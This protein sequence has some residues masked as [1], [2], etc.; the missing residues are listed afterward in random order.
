[1]GTS[2]AFNVYA[3]QGGSATGGPVTGGSATGGNFTKIAPQ[4]PTKVSF[5]IK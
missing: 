3:Q 5:L 2:S 1:M 4:V